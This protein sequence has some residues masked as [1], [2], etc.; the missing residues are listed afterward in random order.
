MSSSPAFFY[1]DALLGGEADFL[2]HLLDQWLSA[3]L[4][5]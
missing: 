3:F 5:L 4:M 2:S 1:N